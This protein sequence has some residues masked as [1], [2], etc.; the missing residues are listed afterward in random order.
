MD[1][2][3]PESDDYDTVGGFIFSLIQEIPSDDAIFDLTYQNY[4]I[5]VDQVKEKRIESCVIKIRS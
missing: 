1:I 5:H 2:L 4:E 3:L